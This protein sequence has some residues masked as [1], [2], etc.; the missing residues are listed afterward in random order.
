M[1]FAHGK[2]FY[3]MNWDDSVY[4]KSSGMQREKVIWLHSGILQSIAEHE[5]LILTQTSTPHISS[6][7]YTYC[8]SS[9]YLN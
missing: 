5:W 3:D 2:L 1:L 9:I 7:I 8:P 4:V 6:L